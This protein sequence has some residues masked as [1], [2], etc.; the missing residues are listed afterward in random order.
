MAVEAAVDLAAPQATGFAIPLTAIIRDG[1]TDEGAENGMSV[2][3]FDPE[4]SQV[5][6]RDVT[7]GGISENAIVVLDGLQEGDRIASAGVSFLKEGQ[8]VRLLD[9]AE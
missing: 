8:E 3:L 1:S 5:A 9:G 2:Y 7:V 4:T 6:R